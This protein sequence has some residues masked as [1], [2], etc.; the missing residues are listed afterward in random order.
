VK[1]EEYT[2][3]PF[4]QFIICL[5]SSFISVWSSSSLCWSSLKIWK[6]SQFIEKRQLSKHFNL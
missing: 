6:C 1:I 3:S 4:I 5:Y 2:I